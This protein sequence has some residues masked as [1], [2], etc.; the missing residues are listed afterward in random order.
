MH[1]SMGTLALVWLSL[2]ACSSSPS[3]ATPV[4]T[5]RGMGSTQASA[6]S[7]VEPPISSDL[8]RLML[9]PFPW[10]PVDRIVA[11][12]RDEARSL[13]P[14]GFLGEASAPRIGKVQAVIGARV[15]VRFESDAVA[16]SAESRGAY[17]DVA[18][19]HGEV[20]FFLRDGSTCIGHLTPRQGGRAVQVGDVVAVQTRRRR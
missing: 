2:G 9:R 15:A 3:S 11:M 7:A 12:A 19:Y 8:R 5:L 13:R 14:R 16:R 1:R 20:E 6:P 18:G 17:A 4:A 10:D